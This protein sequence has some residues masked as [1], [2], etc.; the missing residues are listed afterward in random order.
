MDKH[1]PQIE[2][3][4]I[5]LNLQHEDI[6]LAFPFEERIMLA[7]EYYNGLYYNF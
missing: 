5:L 7:C 4:Y 1:V 3:S 2:E 6:P